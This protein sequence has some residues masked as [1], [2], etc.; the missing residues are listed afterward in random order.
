VLHDHRFVLGS[1]TL[2]RV[3]EHF[4]SWNGRLLTD[5]RYMRKIEY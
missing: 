2:S 5:R 3:A 1:T 4:A